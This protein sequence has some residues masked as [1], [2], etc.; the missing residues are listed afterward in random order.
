MSA[1]GKTGNWTIEKNTIPPIKKT[2]YP[3]ALMKV[4]DCLY[5]T[6]RTYKSMKKTISEASRRTGFKFTSRTVGMDSVRIWRIE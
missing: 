1:R 2:G 4:G 5:I 6:D 3:W